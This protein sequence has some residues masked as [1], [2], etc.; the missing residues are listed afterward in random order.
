MGSGGPRTWQGWV[1]NPS[2]RG[3]VGGKSAPKAGGLG[4]SSR[5]FENLDTL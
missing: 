2:E 1:S 5:K 3:T 4:A